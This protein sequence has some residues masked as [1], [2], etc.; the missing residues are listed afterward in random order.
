MKPTGRL[1][2]PG[3]PSAELPGGMED[4]TTGLPILRTWRGVY[5]VVLCIFMVWVALL[6]M[7]SKMYS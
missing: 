1:T 6:T 4:E 3:D 5:L 2:G 7:L